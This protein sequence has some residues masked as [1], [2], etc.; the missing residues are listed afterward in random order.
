MINSSFFNFLF[1][2][3][4][5]SKSRHL[6]IFIISIF[7]VFVLSSI[8][9]VSK[10][11]EHTM[12]NTLDQQADFTIQKLRAGKNIDTPQ[13]WADQF[14]LIDGVTKATQRVYGQYW[15]EPAER[16]FTIVG[17]DLFEQNIVKQLNSLIDNLD[18]NKFMQKP[19][20]IVGSGVKK[21]LANYHYFDEYNFRTPNRDIQKVY[22]YDV[23]PKNLNIIGNDTILMPMDLAKKILGIPEDYCTDIVLNVPNKLE[24]DNI[25]IKLILQHFDSRI[26]QKEDIQKAYENMFNYKG[27]IFLILYII[28]LFTFVL[29]LYQRYTMIQSSYKKHIGILRSLGWSIKDVLYLKVLENFIISVSAFMIAIVLAYIYVFVFD[30]PFISDIFFGFDNIDNEIK[31]VPYIPFGLIFSIFLLFVVPFISAVLIPVWKIAI[32]DPLEAM[33]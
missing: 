15:Y 33:R 14:I 21:F 27:G 13:Q 32:I 18:I 5:K 28:V 16:Y 2:E 25:K 9:F 31:L 29:I 17:I 23:L 4:Y 10:S 3:L 22:I 11:L 19:H 8:L 1:L 24:R 7:V 30:A 12:L 20:M 26:I 6:A